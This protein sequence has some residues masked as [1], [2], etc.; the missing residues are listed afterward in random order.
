[1]DTFRFTI[2]NVPGIGDLSFDEDNI[3]AFRLSEAISGLPSVEGALTPSFR[4]EPSLPEETGW[5]PFPRSWDPQPLASRLGLTQS[6]YLPF[7]LRLRTT[8]PGTDGGLPLPP[9]ITVG[10]L[11]NLPGELSIGNA[12]AGG[13][14]HL[15][16][17]VF[18]ARMLG[19]A[20]ASDRALD[21][22][23]LPWVAYL[24]LTRRNKVWSGRSVDIVQ[25]IIDTYPANLCGDA[26]FDASQVEFSPEDRST[27]IQFG[28]S[29]LDFVHRILES[30]GLYYYL[31][32]VD[33]RCRMAVASSNSALHEGALSKQSLVFRQPGPE[34]G[35][36]FEAI[37]TNISVQGETT[38]EKA[39]VRDYN[40]FNASAQLEAE[41]PGRDLPLDVYV[42][43]AGFSKLDDGM[44]QVAP[45]C[46][47]ALQSDRLLLHGQGRCHLIAPGEVMGLRAQDAYVLPDP[48]LFAE[49]LAV[50]RAEHV[51]VRRL[52]DRAP[53]YRNLFE[54]MPL[55]HDFRPWRL[56][57]PPILRGPMIAN[58]AA[59]SEGA[60][61]DVDAQK[62]AWIVF[63][64]DRDSIKVRARLSLD[65]AGATH[66]QFFLPRPGDEVIVDF[67]DGDINRP[68]IVG[69]L[70]NS[71]ST[72]A[73][74]PQKS[75]MVAMASDSSGAYANFTGLKDAAGNLIA[76]F[77]H[78]DGAHLVLHADQD[79]DD[80]V[81]R[82]YSFSATRRLERV[83]E[84]FG[85]SIGGDMKVVIEGNLDIEVKGSVNIN[86]PTS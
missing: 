76:L 40:P 11:I 17:H 47:D 70:Y 38:P 42:Y 31:H 75:G 16:G 23:V 46:L 66:G 81:K 54:A 3:L 21:F 72:M 58:V 22:L 10:D 32:H 57:A 51:L 84:N 28:E 69:S 12:L 55:D 43:P 50:R 74:D 2:H 39:T 56:T 71:H 86:L 14:R 65:W 63:K 25:Q 24:A 52:E 68:V 29:D 35:N 13:V 18:Q 36:L 60:T 85:L 27:V 62:G 80:V 78:K 83:N 59:Q 49:K 41:Q 9:T 67:V 4:F 30:D 44:D 73:F 64:W 45:R 15:Y 34:G 37:L 26:E 20:V 33:N 61:S 82:Q 53:Q 79:R 6:T 7:V 19:A 1:M 77:D 8:L 48:S 5:T